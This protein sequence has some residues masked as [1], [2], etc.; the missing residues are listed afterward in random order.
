MEYPST[1]VQYIQPYAEEVTDYSEAETYAGHRSQG[2]LQNFL[3]EMEWENDSTP[4][5]ERLSPIEEETEPENEWDKLEKEGQ[6]IDKEIYV[7]LGN[8]PD[9]LAERIAIYRKNLEKL[10]STLA[11][12][13]EEEEKIRADAEDSTK[14]NISIANNAYDAD[15]DSTN[16]ETAL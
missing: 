11:E 10:L 14:A 2:H 5:L 7:Q 3:K 12:E 15:S 4:I 9:T 8:I 6:E 13:E 1:A 16:S